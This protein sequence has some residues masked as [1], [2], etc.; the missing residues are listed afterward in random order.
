MGSN[1]KG[2]SHTVSRSDDHILVFSAPLSANYYSEIN[3][4]PWFD[5]NGPEAANEREVAQWWGDYVENQKKFQ[6][7]A[8]DVIKR[9][10]REELLQVL[11]PF[12]ERISH[13]EHLK[14]W[15]LR[16]EEASAA[17]TR[18]QRSTFRKP[19]Y[20]WNPRFMNHEIHDRNQVQKKLRE[21]QILVAEVEEVL[22]DIAKYLPHG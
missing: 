1:R 11:E 20:N 7:P 6:P 4:A 15:V 19:F 10:S 21:D 16:N 3:D 17:L 8:H 22:H 13:L 18:Q 14:S 2:G 5:N 12:Q 9:A